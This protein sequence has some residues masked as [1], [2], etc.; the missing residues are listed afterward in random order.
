M[1]EIWKDIEGFEGYLVSNLGRVKSLSRESYWNYKRTR[2]IRERLLALHPDKKGYL[3]AWLYKEGKKH[4]RKVHRLV[5]NAFLPNIENKPQIDHINTNKQDNRVE[6]LRW[7]TGQENSNNPI[8]ARHN[9]EGHYEEKGKCNK[10]V[11]QLTIDGTPIK[12]CIC[13]NKVERELGISHSHII[14]CCKGYRNMAG[15]YKWVYADE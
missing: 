5:A 7:C 6:N 8:T 14:G 12:D 2:T 10:R 1:E 13:I 9:G 11:I 4:T 15:G 3:M